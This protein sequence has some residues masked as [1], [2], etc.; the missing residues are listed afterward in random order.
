DHVRTL[1]DSRLKLLFRDDSVLILAAS[2]EMTIDEQTG[3]AAVPTSRFQLLFGTLKAIVTER[4]SQPHAQFEVETPTAIAGV[5]GRGFI[6]GYDQG[7]DETLVVGLFDTTLVRGRDDAKRT[8][9][10]HLGP[11]QS[12]RVR[13][14]AF[15]LRP[16]RLP[17]ATLRRLDKSTSVGPSAGG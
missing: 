15:P 9:E 2:S 11:G 10:V 7:A 5:R 8:H 6:A 16:I 1:E 13:R 3:A 4:Y 17:D 12:T 14:G